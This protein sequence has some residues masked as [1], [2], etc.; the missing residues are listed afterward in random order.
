MDDLSQTLQG[1][2][3][4]PK[5]MAQVQGLLQSLGGSGEPPQKPAAPPPVP[6]DDTSFLPT[7]RRLGPLLSAA[8]QEDDTTRFLHALRPLLGKARQKKLDEVLKLL[9]LL[10][11]LPLLRNAGLLEGL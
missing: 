3:K 8:R 5:T 6:S 2:L 11:M 9:G 7:L 4:D 1:L 10:R